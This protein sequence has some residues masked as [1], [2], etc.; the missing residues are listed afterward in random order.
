MAASSPAVS[1]LTLTNTSTRC[2]LVAAALVLSGCS[3]FNH[4]W[5]SFLGTTTRKPTPLTDLKSNNAAIAWSTS[6]AKSGGYLFVPSPADKLVYV[7]SND[8]TISALADE[9]GRVVTRIDAKS[10]LTGGTGAGDNF[11]AA[12]NDK[13]EVLAFDAAGRA[14]W[15]T[16]VAGEVL[17]PPVVTSTSVIVR[18]ADGR[19]L[20]LGRADGQRKWVFQRPLPALTLRTNAS[21]LINRGVIYAGFPGGKLVAIEADSGKPV[22]EATVSLPRG[23]TELERVADIGGVPALDD[24]RICASVYQGRTGCVETL[25]GNVLWSREI[26]SAEAVAID[27]KYL[28]VVDVSGNVHALDKSS[29]ASVWK[30]DKLLNRDTNN[31]VML[32]GKLLV[33][34]GK[35]FVHVIS[36][37]T[38]EFAGRV[39]T[40]GSR[41]V[42]L[43]V[44]GSRAIAQ[45]EKGGIYAVR[46]Q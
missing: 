2:A 19:I 22:W 4:T 17:A 18:T 36:P 46:V 9:G 30:Q 29:G 34:E 21:V 40:D 39:S 27:S 20:A 6:V 25:N 33:G 15:K 23:A 31:P 8:G 14:L 28:F 41:I 38:G 16:L 3:Q 37:E 32:G 35:G 44:D 5:L 43:V 12:A 26:S 11:V 24:T 7:A 45:T 42:S 10:R 1:R 13:G